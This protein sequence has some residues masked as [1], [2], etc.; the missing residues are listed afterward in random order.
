MEYV[1]FVFGIFGLIAYIQLSTLRDRVKELESQMAGMEGTSFHD[2]RV[3]LRKVVESYKGSRVKI[4]LKEDYEDADIVIYGNTKHG[5]NTIIDV[6]ED[7]I[8]LRV[9]TPKGTKDKLIR[10]QAVE[11]LTL[12]G[13]E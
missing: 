4:D 13:K 2:D 12:P 11:N 8:L 9:E 10:L 7:W 3:S 1:A 6:D 5:S